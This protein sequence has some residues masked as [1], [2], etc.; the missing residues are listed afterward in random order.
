M[1]GLSLKMSLRG[2]IWVYVLVGGSVLF[3][4][5][6]QCHEI[7]ISSRRLACDFIIL[8]MLSFNVILGIDCLRANY[9]TIENFSRK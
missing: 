4:R 6:C 7:E 1:F 3:H 8:D 9:A 2:L 5:V